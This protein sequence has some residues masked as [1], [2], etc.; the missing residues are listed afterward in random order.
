MDNIQKR[1]ICTV[2]YK[3]KFI[4]CYMLQSSWD[5]YQA[6]IYEYV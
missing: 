3:L 2:Y 4:S 6:V 5:R 1:N